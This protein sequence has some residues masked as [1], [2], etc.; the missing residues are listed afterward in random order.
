MRQGEVTLWGEPHEAIFR[1]CLANVPQETAETLF[2]GLF[3]LAT[4]LRRFEQ[5]PVRNQPGDDC[6]AAVQ[7]VYMCWR[8]S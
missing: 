6:M 2:L 8:R 3:L 5:Y 4:A 7:V 1:R